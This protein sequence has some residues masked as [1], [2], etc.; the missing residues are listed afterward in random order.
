MNCCASTSETPGSRGSVPLGITLLLTLGVAAICAI[1][2]YSVPAFGG[3]IGWV[4][5]AFAA[6]ATFGA[7]RARLPHRRHLV[8][9]LVVL[10]LAIGFALFTGYVLKESSKPSGGHNSGFLFAMFPILFLG[11]TSRKNRCTSGTRAA[12]MMLA[13]IGFVFASIGTIAGWRVWSA[14]QAGEGRLYSALPEIGTFASVWMGAA[15]L[16]GLMVVLTAPLRDGGDSDARSL[17]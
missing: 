6:L 2:L 16:V 11:T 9:A 8:M 12:W 14:V 4:L 17:A 15:L 1:P 10:P 3:A 5:P 13:A 7:L